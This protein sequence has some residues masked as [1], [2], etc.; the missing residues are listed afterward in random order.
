MVA[1]EVRVLSTK[2]EAHSVGTIFNATNQV[3]FY[4]ERRGISWN[5]MVNMQSKPNSEVL[6]N[7][8]K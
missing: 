1:E 2:S 6:C 4:F 3:V 8:E 7:N 5:S